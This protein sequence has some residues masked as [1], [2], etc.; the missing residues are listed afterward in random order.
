MATYPTTPA[1]SQGTTS[2]EVNVTNWNTLID[3]INAIGADLVAARGDGQTFPGV[4]HT[5][6]Q[7]TD[8]DDALQAIRHQFSHMLPTNWYANPNTA[9][10]SFAGEK[11][12]IALGSDPGDDFAVDT[13]K[14]VVEGDTGR[15]GMGTNTPDDLLEVVGA[16][17]IHVDSSGNAAVNI[18]R[19]AT[20]NGADVV[21]STAGTP[22]WYCGTS[23]SSNEGD[24]TEFFIG[25][26]Y[27]GV[28][29]AFW[30]ET[31]GKVGFGDVDP[32][33]GGVVVASGVT[34]GTDSTNNLI[35]DAS[36]G[37]STQ[38]L[39]IGNAAITTSF[40]GAHH[41]RLGDKDLQV[42]ELVV[43]RDAKIYRTTKARD[44]AAIGIFWGITRWQDSFG[45]ELL[46]HKMTS[47]VRREAQEVEITA[48]EAFDDVEVEEEYTAS[49][50]V[51]AVE[52][53]NVV[54]RQE[55]VRAKR[56]TGKFARGLKPRVRL[57]EQTGKLYEMRI[58]DVEYEKPSGEAEPVGDKVEYAYAVACLGDS[59]EEHSETPL[60]GAWVTVDA[61][62][63]EE[64]DFLCSSDKAGYL[65]KQADDVYHNYTVA[66]AGQNITEDTKT[67]YVL[68]L[69]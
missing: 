32:T 63:I 56:G 44:K 6:G 48:Q 52:D 45:T 55:A 3:N 11:M 42:G 31:N 41:Y 62:T 53:G 14:F 69:R 68:F 25:T 13:D 59:Y 36:N 22:S 19:A 16:G 8:L 10:F 50:T 21:F 39:Y 37:A 34:I 15:S 23:D 17:G 35:D 46:R 28:S 26:T 47:K 12:A 58:D 1:L 64:G 9:G 5:A 66:R 4:G 18:D 49:E 24:G 40:T 65:E 29:A 60:T 30:I 27:G 7:A 43:L 33:N 51:Y 67:A 54:S 61:G 57:D 38:T 20:G 2:T